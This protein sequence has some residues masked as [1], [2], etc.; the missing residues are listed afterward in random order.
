MI[1]ENCR[2]DSNLEANIVV[3][4][5]ARL[6]LNG[7]TVTA[8]GMRFNPTAGTPSPGDGIVF[9]D[10]SDGSIS[11]CTISGNT[12]AGVRNATSKSKIRV[13]ES[14]VFNN[15][16]DFVGKIEKK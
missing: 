7:C 14:N 5:N 9:E 13:S 4:D 8:G 16:D 12:A 3:Q 6:T 15:G 1:C 2:F 11:R 10:T